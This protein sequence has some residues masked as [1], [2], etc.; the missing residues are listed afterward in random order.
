M[1]HRKMDVRLL[2]I[3][4]VLAF[5]LLLEWL[6]PVIEL[7]DTNYLGV[8]LLF[9][10]LSFLLGLLR[11]RWWFSLP[12]KGLYLFI[13]LHYVFFKTIVFSR[14]TMVLLMNDLLSNFPIMLAGDWENITNPF[15]TILFFI[16]LWMTIYLIRHWIEVRKSIMLF[17]A[18]TVIFI[19][20]IDTFSP[21]EADGAI[22]RV[23]VI[24]LLLI[25]LLTISR[26]A[27]RHS[28]KV[29]AG[30]F[31]AFSLPLL[32]AVVGSGMVASFLPA[33]EPV[34]AD[35]VP[36]IK[37]F[38]NGEG[39]G[40]GGTTSKSGYGLD[41]SKLGGAFVQ[42]DTVI[43]RATVPRKQYWKI[44]T[45]NTYTSKG[46][47]QNGEISTPVNILSGA[48]LADAPLQDE[49]TEKL[50][51]EIKMLEP[52]PFLVYPYGATEMHTN[53][54]GV[55][56][57]Y[58]PETG[59]YWALKGTQEVELD[60]YRV[61]LVEMPPYSLKAL[62]E[63]SNED[64]DG[65]GDELAQYLQLPEQ[66]PDRVRELAFSITDQEGSVY[67]K[68]KAIERY[69]SRSGF[70]YDQQTVAIPKANEDY[71]D[72]FLFDTKR[73]YCDNFSTSMV[74][75]LRAIDI[76]ARW[77]KGFAPG[78]GK[79]N[80]LGKTEYTITNNEAHS[81]VEAYMPG[82]GWMPFEPTIGFSNPTNIEYD[83]ET[84]MSEPQIPEME[85]RERPE[86]EKDETPILGKNHKDGSS[87][88]KKAMDF[89]QK[90]VWIIIGI[91]VLILL[92]VWIVH[93]RR[94]KWLPK[95]YIHTFRNQPTNWTM[96]AKQYLLLLKQLERV[97][98]KRA[99]SMTL[100]EFATSVDSYFG[101]KQMQKLTEVY[102]QGVYGGYTIDQ[103]WAS[104]K[105]IWEDLII[106]AS[107]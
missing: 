13:A 88:V 93:S 48:L 55:N 96:F 70:T 57:K 41:D 63:T 22:F 75:M 78:E 11:L 95:V 38:V 64:Y 35:P 1:S 26:I 85:E 67:E 44:E 16:L 101:G 49:E 60:A 71:V 90:Y 32:F 14:E 105:E 98:F 50:Q 7:T 17:Y 46:W 56:L 25:G 84:D 83:I 36:F 2:L 39:S 10:A 91:I 87:F 69:F 33:Q 89:I 54:S 31:A 8:F 40:V 9:I 65:S 81:W 99:D 61:E 30:K 20:V 34:W 94:K 73:G 68:A 15:R 79:T 92:V 107:G 86:I 5:V 53:L 102:E 29:H 106:R 4:Y 24:G 21:Y 12:I 52:L 77:A 104:L 72:Q 47:E 27:E 37:S 97:G 76:P 3:L 28:Q 100:S 59:Q 45:K 18:M 62:R 51:A 23:M 43:F 6:L 82:F 66:L 80:S 103:E 42:D 19:A 58:Q 74:V